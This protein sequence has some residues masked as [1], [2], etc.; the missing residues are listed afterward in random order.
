MVLQGCGMISASSS[1][2][3]VICSVGHYSQFN[4][5][6]PN[7]DAGLSKKDLTLESLYLLDVM[8]EKVGTKSTV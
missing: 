5:A 2:G 6:V 1:L 3:L 4:G 7:D 8:T